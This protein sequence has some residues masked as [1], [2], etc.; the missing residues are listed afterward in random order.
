MKAIFCGI[1]GV[2][3]NRE[4]D[5]GTP[6]GNNGISDKL[7]K[8]LERIVSSTG[9]V[10]ILSSKWRLYKNDLA[11]E[12]NYQYLEEKLFGVSG[13]KIT[14]HTVDIRWENR[15]L[16]IR[17]YLN[18]HSEI[19]E[20]VILDETP[21]RGFLN[22]KLFEHLVLTDY[23][24]GLT[25]KDVERAIRILHGEKVEPYD[26]CIFLSYYEQTMGKPISYKCA[27]AIRDK[28]KR[29]VSTRTIC[30]GLF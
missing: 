9:A 17:R 3:K 16:E 2:L 12:K 5:P 4:T 14:D 13:L 15:G 26:R 11:Y 21:F 1:D 7:I 22:D 29:Y 19:A 6:R 23:N 20:F 10:I 18:D 30:S 25:D 27:Y 28:A 8:N 24:K